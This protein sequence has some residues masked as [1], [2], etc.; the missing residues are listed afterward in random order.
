MVRSSDAGGD[1][2]STSLLGIFATFFPPPNLRTSTSPSENPVIPQSVTKKRFPFTSKCF[3][4]FNWPRISWRP[5]SFRIA[6]LIKSCPDAFN[7]LALSRMISV[8]R[9]GYEAT[10]SLMWKSALCEEFPTA[11]GRS[12][13]I[14]KSWTA[15]GDADAFVVVD[16]AAEMP[17]SGK[18]FPMGLTQ[19]PFWMGKRRELASHREGASAQFNVGLLHDH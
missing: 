5:K 15:N 2:V 11:G 8:T 18:Y 6:H 17:Y 9:F 7:P 4:L 1:T 3:N 19:C 14:H 13:I 12:S 16:V 10:S